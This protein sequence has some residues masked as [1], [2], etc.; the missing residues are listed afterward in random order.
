MRTSSRLAWLSFATVMALS[1]PPV[2]ASA[3]RAAAASA[4]FR[5]SAGASIRPSTSA[6]FAFGSSLGLDYRD[7]VLHALWADNGISGDGDL[8]LAAARV[9][10]GGD[11]SV[12]V[13]PTRHVLDA[14]G[15]QSGSSLSIDPTSPSR[16]LG[17]ANGF[18]PTPG[19][20]RA[21]SADDGST[22]ATV[23]DPI[24]EGFGV[25]SP[26]V[27]CDEHGNCFL[28]Y[29]H[30]ADPF[31]PQL[32]LSLSTD[33]GQNFAPV[34][35]PDVP[36][37]EPSVAIALGPGSV[38]LAFKG[39]TS[40]PVIRTLAAP[41]TGR[42]AIGPFTLQNVPASFL[43]DR[44]DIAIGPAGQAVVV[45]DHMPNGSPGYVEARVD[46]DG[47]GPAGFGAPQIVSNTVGYPHA[48]TPRVAWGHDLDRIYLVYGDEQF[49][50]G[51]RDVL[52]RISDDA[53]AT[54]SGA[55]RVNAD[56]F[57]EDRLIPNVAIDQASGAVAVAWYDFRSAP[58]RAELYGRIL[59][60]TSAPAEPASP[61]SLRATPV[62]RTQVDLAWEDRSGNETGFEIRRMSGDPADPA[63]DVTT[64]GANVTAHAVTGLTED[65]TYRFVV[66]AFNASGFSGPTNEAE[67]TTLATPPDAPSGLAATGVTFQRID[68][69]WQAAARATAYEIEQSLD[70][71]SWATVRTT[72][73]TS[74]MLFGLESGT[75]YS[76]RVRG[77]NSGG[78]G[79]YSN[80]ATAS[81][82]A[83]VPVAP[84]GLA[85][86]AVSD[87]RIDLRWSS[88][89]PATTRIVIEA[90]TGG[91]PFKQVGSVTAPATSFT[92]DRLKARTTYTYRIVACSDV[93]CSP[94]SATASATTFDRGRP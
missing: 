27:A 82:G 11:G 2:S 49:G 81:T 62:S 23:T 3:A 92:D 33:G 47:L 8:D 4:D 85:A 74:A 91:R 71:S 26:Q 14:A 70:G 36:G 94:P 67:A 59:T 56:V 10:V 69:A 55:T 7:G 38:W 58:G 48:A 83:S 77:I 39:Y 78:P 46:P 73:A 13:G 35:I 54:W 93:G 30:L 20:V 76:F 37:F 29:I 52:L 43:A 51:S 15:S 21:R 64:V 84:T 60:S 40:S 50:T 66:R 42:G 5:I 19:L 44:P 80:V 79:P 9:A 16:V 25:A 90:S 1:L 6:D 75:T 63:V 24:G 31:D 18:A 41:V 17:A 89:S 57:S 87:S 22:W 32:R 45:T 86:T 12:A 88:V 34:A 53:G 72:S 28:A 65:T 61:V 68:L